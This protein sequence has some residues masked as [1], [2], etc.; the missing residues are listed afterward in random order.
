MGRLTHGKAVGTSKSPFFW[1]H[2][3]RLPCDIAVGYFVRVGWCC[4]S[5]LAPAGWRR[6]KR[7]KEQICFSKKAKGGSLLHHCITASCAAYYLVCVPTMTLADIARK[8]GRFVGAGGGQWGGGSVVWVHVPEPLPPPNVTEANKGLGEGMADPLL[9]PADA[10]VRMC[11]CA[12]FTAGVLRI[13]WTFLC[14]WGLEEEAGGSRAF[15][16]VPRGGAGQLYRSVGY[17]AVLSFHPF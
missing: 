16:V 11:T 14:L 1:P 13:W 4:I 12:H 8:Q 6:C 17:S 15:Q 9:P 7:K 3:L 10:P 2:M 5:L